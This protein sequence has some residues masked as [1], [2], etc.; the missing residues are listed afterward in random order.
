MMVSSDETGVDPTVDDAAEHG[1]GRCW[2]GFSHGPY[3]SASAAPS[4]AVEVQEILG[5][6]E[7]N[8]GNARNTHERIAAMWNAIVPQGTRIRPVDVALMMASLKILR[9]SKNPQHRDS[10][11]DAIGY[12][13]IAVDMTEAQD[14]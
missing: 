10:F 2:C 1:T 14:R 12:L 4:V 5:E 13:Q 9:A 8:Y 3:H 11:V 7:L 6:R